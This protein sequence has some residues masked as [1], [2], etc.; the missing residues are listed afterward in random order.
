MHYGSPFTNVIRRTK[1]KSMDLHIH[2]NA[3]FGMCE[4]DNYA[5]RRRIKGQCPVIQYLDV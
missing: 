2:V 3:R 1:E 5:M 4:R